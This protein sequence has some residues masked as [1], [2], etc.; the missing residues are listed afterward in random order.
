MEAEVPMTMGKARTRRSENKP[1][2]CWSAY[3]I[4]GNSTNIYG[5]VASGRTVLIESGAI[6]GIPV[7]NTLIFTLT[8]NGRIINHGTFIIVGVFNGIP[9][10]CNTRD[11]GN[12]VHTVAA[13]GN[14]A[15][16][17]CA[18]GF[19]PIRFNLRIWLYP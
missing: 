16:L 7:Y 12:I 8:N 10:L 19:D 6:A 18:A 9:V 2:G 5:T 13:C 3:Y 1:R 15:H 11:G 14:P 17:Q 4:T